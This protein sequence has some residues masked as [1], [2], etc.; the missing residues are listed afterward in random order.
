MDQKNF[1][2]TLS[3]KLEFDFKH[4]NLDVDQSFEKTPSVIDKS[5]IF[6]E[7]TDEMID[8][9]PLKRAI[10]HLEIPSQLSAPLIKNKGVIL[11]YAQDLYGTRDDYFL[12]KIIIDELALPRFAVE[13]LP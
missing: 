9:S 2:N 11:S 7:F 4:G 12:D 8:E 1:K 10:L 6:I 13:R 5:Q 3:K